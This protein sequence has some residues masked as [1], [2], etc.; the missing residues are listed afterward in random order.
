MLAVVDRFHNHVFSGCAGKYKDE[1]YS[2][3][4]DLS[5]DVMGKSGLEN[6]ERSST[7]NSSYVF[8][9]VLLRD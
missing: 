1:R 2:Y 6:G 7:E 9:M 3:S 8:V 5:L 4:R